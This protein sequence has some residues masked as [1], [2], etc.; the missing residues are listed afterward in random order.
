MVE[1]TKLK[2]ISVKPPD[3]THIEMCPLMILQRTIRPVQK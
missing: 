2:A 1:I 3:I